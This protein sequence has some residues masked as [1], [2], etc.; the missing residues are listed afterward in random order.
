M[1]KLMRNLLRKILVKLLATTM[2]V[3]VA[4]LKLFSPVS[5]LAGVLLRAV[6]RAVFALLLPLFGAL[7]ALKRGLLK[8]YAPLE[9]RSRILHLFTRRYVFHVTF[10]GIAL[11]VVTA[12]LNAY[13]VK[14]DEFTYANVFTGLSRDTTYDELE[15]VRP[16][17][18]PVVKHYY[19]PAAV[20]PIARL[21]TAAADQELSP[22]TTMGGSAVVKPLRLPTGGTAAEDLAPGAP[23]SDIMVYTVQDGDT[24]S[25][26]A[27][28]FGISINTILWENGLTA[29]SI[30][31]PGQKLTILPIS[32]LRHKVARGET[33]G[34]IATRYS[35][36]ADAIISAN[37]LASA[38]DLQVGELLLVPGGAKPRPTPTYALQ[39]PGASTPT[40]TGSGKMGWPASCRRI[41]QYFGWRHTGVDIACSNGTAVYAAD[42]GRVI[43]AQGG[44]NGGY[45]IMVVLQ[46]PDGSQTLYGHN[47]KLYVQ[48]GDEV[49]RGQAIAAIGS[50]GRSTGPH[51]HFEVRAGGYRRN[52]FSYLK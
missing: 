36:D 26:V 40:I 27:V 41:T 19:S 50:T 52:P 14:R 29:Y 18:S 17:L 46:H 20:S 47:S 3:A 28:R 43:K 16:P 2:R 4:V 39:R 25:G 48:V 1:V 44:W 35:V 15:E 33:V 37:K 11:T 42:D 12:N 49:A 9:Q 30:I 8:F 6:G 5:R 38:N 34:K 21:D 24:I 13:E 10:I 31:R 23:R 32:G 45:G 7:L 22:A 51:L